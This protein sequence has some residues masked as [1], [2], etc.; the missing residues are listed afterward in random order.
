MVGWLL[1]VLLFAILFR[2]LW[3]LL[4]G[5]FQ[6]LNAPAGGARVPTDATRA[7]SPSTALVKDPVCGTYVARSQALSLASAD[8]TYYFCSE[9][10]RVAFQRER[11]DRAL[12]ASR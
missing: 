10:C 9:D 3:R 11:Q 6:G 5:V 4:I 7:P 8:A 12:H 1:R 2:A